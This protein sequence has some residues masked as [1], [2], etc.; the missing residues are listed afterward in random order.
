MVRRLPF[1]MF[2]LVLVGCGP[3]AALRNGPFEPIA[4]VAARAGSHEG[5]RVRWGGTIVRATP[6]AEETCL[7]VVSRP[8]NLRARPLHVDDSDG[9]FL[10]CVAGFLDP[11]VYAPGRMVTV[12]GTRIWNI[13]LMGARFASM[14]GR[15][16]PTMR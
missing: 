1:V 6:E 8:L 16:D 7:E 5:A 13:L 9:R 3:P 12:V 2:A 4:V 10:A 11:A 15:S 14:S